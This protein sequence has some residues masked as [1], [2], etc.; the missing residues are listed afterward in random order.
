MTL[1][2]RWQRLEQ[3]QPFAD[4]NGYGPEW[5]RMCAARTKDAAKVAYAAKVAWALEEA[6]TVWSAA[7]VEEVTDAAVSAAIQWIEKAEGKNNDT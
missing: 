7:K 2:E 3:H 6:S 4:A 1:E 5:A